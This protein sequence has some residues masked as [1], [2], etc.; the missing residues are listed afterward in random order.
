MV[1]TASN[2]SQTTLM[3]SYTSTPHGNPRNSRCRA[4]ADASANQRLGGRGGTLR[5]A[6]EDVIVLPWVFCERSTVVRRQTSTMKQ[7]RRK[8]R[9]RKA[10]RR[11]P[12]ATRLHAAQR[13]SFLAASRRR[14]RYQR[15]REGMSARTIAHHVHATKGPTKRQVDGKCWRPSPRREKTGPTGVARLAL[16]FPADEP[17]SKW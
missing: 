6:L 10:P 4:A 15:A 16:R 17:S 9:G 2:F 14:P 13:R 12:R 5:H 11:H 8:M 1:Q 7:K 3:T